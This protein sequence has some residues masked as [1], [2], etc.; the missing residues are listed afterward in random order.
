MEFIPEK[1]KKPKVGIKRRY[2]GFITKVVKK[3]SLRV[4]GGDGG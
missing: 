4:H 2:T 1:N 3:E